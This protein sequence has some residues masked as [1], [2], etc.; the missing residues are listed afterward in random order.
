MFV[1]EAF[2]LVDGKMDFIMLTPMERVAFT[3]SI[4]TA[5]VQTPLVR[6][7]HGRLEPVTT[8]SGIARPT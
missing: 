7:Q 4:V 1:Q 8:A 2:Y 5:E 3:A 6:D